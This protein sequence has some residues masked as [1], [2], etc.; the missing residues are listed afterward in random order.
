M[1]IIGKTGAGKSSTGNLI[2][3]TEKFKAELSAS[4]VTT[5]TKYET[6][7]R[8]GKKLVVVDTPG[9]KDTGKNEENIHNEINKWYTLMSPGIHAILLV[10]K[11]DRFTD[12]EKDTVDFFMKI[13]GERIKDYLI[14]FFL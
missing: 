11:G 8:F 9:V 13:F 6:A 3:G 12:E 7:Q 5:I 1:L 14:I 2:L 10:I 4:S